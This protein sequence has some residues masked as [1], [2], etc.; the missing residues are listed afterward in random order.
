MQSLH[1]N[2]ESEMLS[3]ISKSI[4][5]NNEYQQKSELNSGF[6]IADL[7]FYKL[8]NM[9][10]KNRERQN[11]H[12]IESYE[13]LKLL[14]YLNKTSQEKISI[15]TI[16]NN[17]SVKP[18]DEKEIFTYLINNGYLIP[19]DNK[20]FLKGKRYELGLREVIAIE[21]KL[22]NWQRGL[23]QAYRY[24]RYSNKAYLALSSDYI[25]RAL[26]H[27]QDFQKFNVGLIEVSNTDTQIHYEPK[28]EGLKENIFSASV[29]EKLLLE[30][31]TLPYI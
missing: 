13:L 7:V 17:L 11:L 8:D 10:I 21:A 29:F 2:T 24:K 14:T 22:S 6:G 25:H 31:Y 26:H 27:L 20:V 16:K 28:Y 15:T 3:V 9:V 1:F 30:K 4:S 12:P 23:Y 18:K 5:F 19:L